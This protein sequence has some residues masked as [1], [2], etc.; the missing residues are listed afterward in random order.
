ML[1]RRVLPDWVV[2]AEMDP[3]MADP[4][5]LFPVER[6][7]HKAKVLHALRA[8]FRDN[9]KARRL[10][11]DGTYE[12]RTPVPGEPP[13]R[14]QQVLQDEARDTAR[15][16]RESAGVT[17]TPEKAPRVSESDRKSGS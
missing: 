3:A 9:V 8:M 2:A 11:A 17:F 4:G 10:R 12:R 6:A 14:E 5:A 7:D 16:A 13:Y 1:I 15:L